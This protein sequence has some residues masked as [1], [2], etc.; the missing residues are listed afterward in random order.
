MM[1]YLTIV[2]IAL[3]LFA[4]ACKGDHVLHLTGN[5]AG[6]STPTATPGSLDNGQPTNV[7]DIEVAVANEI[8]GFGGMFVDPKQPDR[9]KVYLKDSKDLDSTR[10]ALGKLVGHYPQFDLNKV[11]AL[12]GRYGFLELVDWDNSLAQKTAQIPLVVYSGVQESTNQ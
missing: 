8:P 5:D 2:G 12:P 9:L 7:R 3:T 6:I 4:I 10:A 11:D 1:R